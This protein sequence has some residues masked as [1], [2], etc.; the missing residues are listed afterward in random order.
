VS[1]AERVREAL[2]GVVD[3]CAAATGSKLNVVEMG[4][5]EGVDVDDGHVTVSMRLTTPACFMIP[6][7]DR[8]VTACV[9]PL[10]GVR[11]VELETDDG[12][13]WSEDLM[14]DAAREKRRDAIED[15]AASLDSRV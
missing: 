1:T 7:F 10:D 6:Q 14:S 15:G 9:E 3:P 2:R 12:L 8:E 11:S 13:Q 4:L 5:V